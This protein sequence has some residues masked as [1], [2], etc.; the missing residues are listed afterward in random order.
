MTDRSATTAQRFRFAGDDLVTFEAHGF[1]GDW[2]GALVPIVDAAT[3]RAVLARLNE[4]DT[5]RRVAA[6]ATRDGA[7]Q[8][9]EFWRDGGEPIGTVVL[10]PDQAGLYILDCGLTLSDPEEDP[11]EDYPV[12]WA[13]EQGH[14]AC[15]E[16]RGRIDDREGRPRTVGEGGGWLSVAPIIA[17]DTTIDCEICSYTR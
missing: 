7:V 4:H 1:A 9:T 13:D 12:L 6:A 14:I 10:T 2:N 3:L 16:H 8:V 11:D 17:A 5:E 15:T